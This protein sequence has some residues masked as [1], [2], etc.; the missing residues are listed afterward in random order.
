MREPNKRPEKDKNR[1]VKIMKTMMTIVILV[2]VLKIVTLE[3]G[4]L[5]F[6]Q[7]SPFLLF[8]DI[9]FIIN[10]I[11]SS[12]I[13]VDTAIGVGVVFLLHLILR[14]PPHSS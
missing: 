13:P 9:A 8:Y 5:T 4:E 7:M 1:R 10:F 12:R 11:Y 2:V 3:K 14:M 6:L